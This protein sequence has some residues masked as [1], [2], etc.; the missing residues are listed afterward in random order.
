[1]KFALLFATQ[2]T[3]KP[4][5]FLKNQTITYSIVPYAIFMQLTVLLQCTGP[6]CLCISQLNLI[7][8]AFLS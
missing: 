8:K 5:P 6:S 4:Y 1:M 2:L 3:V 7:E